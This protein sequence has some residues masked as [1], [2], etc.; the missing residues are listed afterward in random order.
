[1]AEDVPASRVF[2]E[3]YDDGT[4]IREIIRHPSRQSAGKAMGHYLIAMSGR[5]RVVAAGMHALFHGAADFFK[6]SGST[7]DHMDVMLRIGSRVYR[8]RQE[9][10]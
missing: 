6:A 1:M 3:E 5:P 2:S 4:A 9:Q 7:K 8:V 10:S